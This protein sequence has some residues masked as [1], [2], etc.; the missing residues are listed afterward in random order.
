MGLL[1]VVRLLR[2]EQTD[3]RIAALVGH[4]RPT[5]ARY[6]RGRRRKDC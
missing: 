3:H 1:E 6:R 2:V 4:N 5:I